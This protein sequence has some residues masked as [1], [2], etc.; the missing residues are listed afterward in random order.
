M[1]SPAAQLHL[2]SFLSD[3][4]LCKLTDIHR[5]K[6]IVKPTHM[7]LRSHIVPHKSASQL[8]KNFVALFWISFIG[9]FSGASGTW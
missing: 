1:F 6:W 8:V 5:V 4:I 7:M 2:F 3:H 9:P